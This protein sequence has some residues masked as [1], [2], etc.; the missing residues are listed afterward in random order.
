MRRLDLVC[1]VCNFISSRSFNV[2]TLYNDCLRFEDVHQLS[3]SHFII[4]FSLFGVLNLDS[5]NSK[6]VSGLCNI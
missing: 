1:V 5:P 2:I 3:C 6:M 4:C